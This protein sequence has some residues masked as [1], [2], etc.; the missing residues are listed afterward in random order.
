MT[1][2]R[3]AAHARWVTVAVA[4]FAAWQLAWIADQ[5]TRVARVLPSPWT[6]TSWMI[7]WAA[8]AAVASVAAVTASDLATRIAFGA[9]LVVEGAGVL[10]AIGV[11]TPTGHQ[12]W[13]IGQAVLIM[14]VMAALLAS[15]LRSMPRIDDLP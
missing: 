1:T 6:V 8:V 9:L 3:V 2:G 15:P 4:V 5:S 14:A 7:A 12:F 13:T 10:V 11:D